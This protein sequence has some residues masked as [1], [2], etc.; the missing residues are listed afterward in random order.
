MTNHLTIPEPHAAQLDILAEARRFNVVECGRRWGKTKMGQG[1]VMEC[2]LDGGDAG[3]F[4]PSYKYFK[5]VWRALTQSLGPAITDKDKQEGFIELS[6][7]GTIEVWSLHNNEDAG[8]SRAYDVAVIDEAAYCGTLREAWQSAIRPTLT[9]RRGKAWFLS[10]PHGYEYFHELFERG[11]GEDADW[12]SWRMGTVTN[13]YISAD[14]IEAAR[15]ELPEVV[16]E[17]EY[18]GIPAPDG[19]NPFGIEDIKACTGELSDGEPLVYGVDLAKSID[20]TVV[21]G[22]DAGGSVCSFD[23]WHKRSWDETTKRVGEIVGGRPALVD[24]TGVGDPIVESLERDRPAIE[25]FKFTNTSKQQIMEGL[26]VAIQQRRITFPDG[27]IPRELRT[28]R[29]ELTPGGRVR[30]AAPEG[31][32]DDCVC[33]LALAVHH[34][35]L[36]EGGVG[37]AMEKAATVP[38]ITDMDHHAQAAREL[39]EA[40]EAYAASFFRGGDE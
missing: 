27:D 34:A 39:R 13:P 9:D 7:G 29:Y 6:T 32:H 31:L 38:D 5:M 4:V 22:L 16:F 18:L 25:G 26:S 3:W 23:R 28:F 10:T 30:Y 8:R 12:A 40:R 20:Y 37:V 15:Q 2:A 11:Q 19:G 14:E 17:Q 24:S 33:A 35:R 36:W 21:I 1:I